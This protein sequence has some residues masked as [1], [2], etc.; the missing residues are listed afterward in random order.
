LQ[1]AGVTPQVNKERIREGDSSLAFE[2]DG[3][4]ALEVVGALQFTMIPT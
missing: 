2:R 1:S 4:S 3:A